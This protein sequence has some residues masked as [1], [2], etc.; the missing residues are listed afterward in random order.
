MEENLSLPELEAILEAYR[1]QI[2]RQNKFAAALKGID[3]EAGAATSAEDKVQEVKN[4]VAAKLNG[5]S[6]EEYEFGSMGLGIEIED[7]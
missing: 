4:R 7:E 6:Q 3:L 5:V 1:D 2:Y